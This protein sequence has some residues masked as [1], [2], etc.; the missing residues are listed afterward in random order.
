MQRL[1][2]RDRHVEHRRAAE[3][4]ALEVARRDA[5]D[6]VRLAV[7]DDVLLEHLRVGAE[8]V[9]PV[10]V[11]EHRH[12]LSADG[13]VVSRIEQATEGGPDAEHREV[14]TG[15]HH[16][17]AVQRLVVV[18]DVGPEQH[19]RREPAELR[20]RSFE[21]AKHLVAEDRVAVA[22]RAAALASRVRARSADVD[23]TLR[24]VHGER[25]QEHLVERRED[26]GI[27]ADAEREGEHRDGRDERRLGQ[28]AEGEA[29]VSHC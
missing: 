7:D 19:V 8:L 13:L 17:G 2:H 15:D 16:P 3:R 24:F 12:E 6:R 27:G 18:G 23:E 29:E 9:R 14:G 22:G 4:G 26:G 21:V 10:G 11:A 28:R 20:L 5:D 25:T 1:A